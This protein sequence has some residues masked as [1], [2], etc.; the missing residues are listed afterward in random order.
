MMFVYVLFLSW[1]LSSFAWN[2]LVLKTRK[3]I[4]VISYQTHE[5]A[6]NQGG[7]HKEEVRTPSR[8]SKGHCEIVVK[9]L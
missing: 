8:N 2:Q 6:K 1:L 7:Y 9:M 3:E 5:K 4:H